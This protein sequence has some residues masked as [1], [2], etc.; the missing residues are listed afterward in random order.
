M[1]SD[2]EYK[3]DDPELGEVTFKA[4]VLHNRI[5]ARLY[6]FGLKKMWSISSILEREDS[7][8]IIITPFKDKITLCEAAYVESWIEGD[9]LY[10]TL[11]LLTLLKPVILINFLEWI[12]DIS[13]QKFNIS[14]S[15]IKLLIVTGH[16]PH[17]ELEKAGYRK[18]NSYY[19][20]AL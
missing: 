20:K 15:T 11:A 8:E 17:E 2:I 7:Y 6:L 12:K 1:P 9:S 19:T 4:K 16:V 3:F 5:Q 10:M 14:I 18:T 13:R